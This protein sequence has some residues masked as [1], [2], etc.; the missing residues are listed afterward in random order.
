MPNPYALGLVA[1]AL[2]AIKADPLKIDKIYEKLSDNF[3]IYLFLTVF[4]RFDIFIAVYFSTWE[5]LHS[6]IDQELPNIEGI[7]RVEPYF[8]KERKKGYPPFY[9]DVFSNQDK[10]QPTEFDWE[11]IKELVK[12]GRQT[13]SY[14]SKKFGV[15]QSTI[16]RRINYFVKNKILMIS[17][18]IDID[19]LGLFANAYIA[20][21][22]DH[23]Q[24]ENI[25]KILSSYPEVHLIMTL[26]NGFKIIIGIHTFDNKKLYTFIMQKLARIKGIYGTETFIRAEVKKRY[27]G[28]SFSEYLSKE[29]GRFS[30]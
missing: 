30:E 29:G 7:I 25:C 27:Y 22:V 15:H 10:F 11:L 4:G 6:F 14:L 16:S 5:G 9:E 2:I 18:I 12:N 1:H 26:I 28:C 3:N 20:L 24:I 17:A 8:A 19:Y 21:E 13:V 23:T